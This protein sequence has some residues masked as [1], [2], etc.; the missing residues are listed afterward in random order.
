MQPNLCSSCSLESPLCSQLYSEGG[1]K[2]TSRPSKSSAALQN[3]EELQRAS[4]VRYIA[5]YHRRGLHFMIVVRRRTHFIEV[6]PQLAQLKDCLHPLLFGFRHRFNGTI[7]ALLAL[8]HDVRDVICLLARDVNEVEPQRCLVMPTNR[9][10]GKPRL[11]QP[12]TVRPPSFHFSVI[13]RPSRPYISMPQQWAPA[14]SS[15]PV[16]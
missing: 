14:A 10:L 8:T 2:A 5:R 9:Q 7:I 4:S 12:C 11:V 15:K 13:L 3:L 1:N 6:P 16:A